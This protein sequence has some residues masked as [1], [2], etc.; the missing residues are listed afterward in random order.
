MYKFDVK[1]TKDD[2]L[3]YYKY[4]LIT[5]KIFR[6]I[7]FTI[8]FFAIA[9]YWLLDKNSEGIFIPILCFVLGLLMPLMNFILLPMMK[10]QLNGR[11]KQIAAAKINVTFNDEDIIY[12]NNSI[13]LEPEEKNTIEEKETIEEETSENKE[14]KSTEEQE[15][16]KIVE[17]EDKNVVKEEDKNVNDSE[18][19]D[20]KERVFNLKY[21][22]FYD[23]RETKNLLLFSL[24]YQT[25]ILL[26]KRCIVE[27]EIVEFK[28]F[29]TTKIN[30]KRLHLTKEK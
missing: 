7:I 10:K 27:G 3:E 19:T 20:E 17:E 18:I 16:V 28:K 11:E 2:Y 26:P 24:D 15:A 6:N 5:R 1:Y 29:L 4:I 8:L 23:V 30:L 21:S 9:I 14:E 22:N 12:E 25:V 13:N